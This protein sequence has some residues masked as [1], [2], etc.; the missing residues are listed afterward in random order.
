MRCSTDTCPR[1]SYDVAI[2]GAG[3]AGMAT[4]ARLQRQGLNT[5]VLEAHRQAGGCAGY[6][7]RQGFSFD[8]GATTLV[9]F[10]PGGIGSDLL[11]AIGL[12]LSCREALPGYVAWLPDRRVTLFRD[13]ELWNRER[14]QALGQSEQHR[15]FWRLIDRLAKV[16]W[17]A[18]RDGVV[19][20]ML[21]ARSMLS[22]L[23]VASDLPV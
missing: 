18:S 3:I 15:N 10:E 7:C 20:P 11:D 17:R 8:V 16:F 4:A 22:R 19:L 23:F 5:I 13:Q 12:N 9:D 14:L 1:N 2:I 21:A 6:Y